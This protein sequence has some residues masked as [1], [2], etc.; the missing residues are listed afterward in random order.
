M[1]TYSKVSEQPG[2]VSGTITTSQNLKTSNSMNNTI[3]TKSAADNW[4]VLKHRVISYIRMQRMA[5]N[6]VGIKE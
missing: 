5:E 4:K 2:L 6:L 1:F 3:P